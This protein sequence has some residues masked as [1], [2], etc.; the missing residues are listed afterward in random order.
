[1]T[2]NRHTGSIAAGWGGRVTAALVLLW[3]VGMELFLGIEP[4]IVDFVLAFIIGLFLW[5][6][7]LRLDRHQQVRARLPQ[8]RPTWRDVR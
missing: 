6:R 2:G 7:R 8:L 5:T 3:L 4:Q 1:M